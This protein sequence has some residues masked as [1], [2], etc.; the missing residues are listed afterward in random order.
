[1]SERASSFNNEAARQLAGAI[2]D[3]DAVRML[4]TVA[5]ECEGFARSQLM[6]RGVAVTDD[7]KYIARPWLAERFARANSPSP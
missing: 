6:P 7:D 4:L 5:A 2:T 1:M 3:V